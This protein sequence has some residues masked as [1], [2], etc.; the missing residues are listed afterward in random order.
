MI[1]LIDAISNPSGGG[2]RHLIEILSNYDK[3]KSNFKKIILWSTSEFLSQVNNLDYIEKHTHY[4]LNKGYISRLFWII[5]FRNKSYKGFDI[6]F[7]PFGTYFNKDQNYVSMSQNMLPFDLNEISK[8]S[9]FYK[10]KFHLLRFIQK[11]S[12]KNAK[13]LIFISNYASN[14]IK[15][16]FSI[17]Y[18][19]S[20]VIN[21]GISDDFNFPPKTQKSISL[22]NLGTPFR[23]LY[24]SSIWPYKH[25]L[26]LVKAISLL[27]KE[28][29][30]INL[31]IIGNNDYPING[32]DLNSFIKMA[33]PKSEYIIW[34][35]N[36]GINEVCSYYGESDGFIFPSSCENMPNI[37][38]EAMSS[39]LPILCSLHQPMPEFL[40]D[41]GIYFN[42]ND[43][44]DIYDKI[45]IFLKDEILRADIS[46]KSYNLSRDYSWKKCASETFEFLYQNSL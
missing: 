38:I 22:Y 25:H 3:S 28:G 32:T 15:N 40:L 9:L 5:F 13:G 21:H 1:L 20:K 31:T 11:K 33:D 36:V 41:A 16:L 4:L 2:K 6:I 10:I 14:V 12:F 27:R 30:P 26:E 17:N 34:K 29:Y 18:I 44:N 42:P 46:Q 24:V 7:S 43:V 35:Q 45:K 19:N 8:F 39:G 37:L 23:L